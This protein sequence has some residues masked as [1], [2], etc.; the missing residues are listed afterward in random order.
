MMVI[1]YREQQRCKK[2]QEFLEPE[3]ESQ[4]EPTN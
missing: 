3:A 2:L 4:E 1:S